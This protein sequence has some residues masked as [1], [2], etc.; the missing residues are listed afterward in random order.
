V[1]R[2]RE[3]EIRLEHGA[4]KSLSKLQAEIHDNI[5]E[6]LQMLR[7]EPRPPGAEKMSGGS[8][9][10]RIRVQNFRIV[11]QL[12]DGQQ[13]IDVVRIGDRNNVYKHLRIIL[14]VTGIS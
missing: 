1:E 14:S 9:Y 11:Y 13:T 3:Y 12:D 2:R 5:I 10:Y 4:P 6:H 7:T 8:G